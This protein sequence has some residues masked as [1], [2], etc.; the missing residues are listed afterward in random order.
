LKGTGNYNLVDISYDLS[1]ITSNE[2]SPLLSPFDGY[3]IYK[4]NRVVE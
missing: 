3:W 2:A 1:N 4:E